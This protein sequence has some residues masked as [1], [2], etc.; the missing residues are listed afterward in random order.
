MGLVNLD[1]NGIGIRKKLFFF[2]CKQ[3]SRPV[4]VTLPSPMPSSLFIP[5]LLAGMIITV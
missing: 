3:L 1:S 2:G 4:T 5:F